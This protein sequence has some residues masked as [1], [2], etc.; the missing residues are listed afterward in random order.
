[1]PRFR[2][3]ERS[4]WQTH[5][6]NGWLLLWNNNS[7]LLPPS[8]NK[9]T[10]KYSAASSLQTLELHRLHPT[11]TVW[12]EKCPLHQSDAQ[13]R[14]SYL[15]HLKPRP[16]QEG[17]QRESSK[18]AALSHLKGKLTS[19]QAYS[20]GHWFIC[21]NTLGLLTLQFCRLL[22]KSLGSQ[23]RR[24][25]DETNEKIQQLLAIK[26]SVHQAHL[27]QTSPCEESHLLSC[28]QQPPAQTK[29][30][31]EDVVSCLIKENSDL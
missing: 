24:T 18:L 2:N 3:V 26:R 31:R 22:K 21:W 27:A 25:K 11:A 15:L 6:D 10:W 7:L 30:H 12:L 5:N 28:M 29:W 13:G 9:K 8:S 16:K 20:W 23:Q 19:R 4:T 14:T 17:S 1:M